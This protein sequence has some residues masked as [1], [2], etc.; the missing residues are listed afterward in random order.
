MR[1]SP[2]VSFCHFDL[3]IWADLP[4]TIDMAVPKMEDTLKFGISF[5]YSKMLSWG[6]Q[7]DTHL[8]EVE[9]TNHP[10]CFAHWGAFAAWVG[11]AFETLSRKVWW[12][13]ELIPEVSRSVS[14]NFSNYGCGVYFVL[15]WEE[16]SPGISFNM[17]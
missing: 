8:G 17:F 9:I 10:G 3:F 14:S 6:V 4:P 13:T 2:F 12:Q 5:F 7:R 16:Y 11:G 15:N 1:L